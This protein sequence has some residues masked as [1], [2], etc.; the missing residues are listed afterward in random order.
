M[1]PIRQLRRLLAA[2]LAIA[3]VLA[4]SPGVLAAAEDASR[5]RSS[6]GPGLTTPD[7]LRGAE[8]P[9]TGRVLVKFERGA[10]RAARDESAGRA[11]GRVER[12]AGLGWTVVEPEPGQTPE[13]LLADLEADPL[14]DEAQLENRY[15]L[16]APPNDTHFGYQWPLNNTGTVAGDTRPTADADIDWLEAYEEIDTLPDPPGDIVVAVVDSGIDETHVDLDDVLWD[17]G[18][19]NPGWDFVGNDAD[20]LDT[21]GHGTHVAGT[22]AA[23]TDNGAGVAGVASHGTKLMILRVFGGPT[24]GGADADI[25]DAFVYA[26]DNGADIINASFTTLNPV[27]VSQVPVLR[28]AVDYAEDNGVLVVAAAGNGVGLPPVGWDNDSLTAFYPASFDNPNI[29]SVAASTWNDGLTDWSNYGVT[30]VDLAAPG[31]YKTSP[32]G[33][34]RDEILSTMRPEVFNPLYWGTFDPTNEYAYQSGTSMAAPHVAGAAALVMYKYPDDWWGSV[35]YRVLNGADTKAAFA[36]KVATGGR[37]NADRALD[38]LAPAGTMSIDAGATYTNSTNVSVDSEIFAAHS[39]GIDPTGSDPTPSITESFTVSKQVSMP[40]GDGTKTI[41]AAY[42]GLDPPI[43]YRADTIVLDTMAPSTPSG[44]QAAPGSRKA[45]L[46]WSASADE[47]SGVDGYH[48]YRA[49]S[50]NGTYTRVT[51]APV[52]GTS[53]VDEGLTNGDT[54]HYKVRSL[55]NAGNQSALSASVS[56]APEYEM[57]RAAGLDRYATAV[58][59]SQANFAAATHVV[60][61]TGEDFPDAL[62]AAGLAGAYDAPVLLTR[63]AAL[64]ADVLGEIARLG[65]TEVLVVGGTG[66]VSDA[67]ADSLASQGLSV[68]RTAGPDR[69]ATAAA[70]ASAIYAKEG[71]DWVGETFIARGDEF[72]DA[73]A[74]APFAYSQKMPVLLVRPTGSPPPATIAA[75]QNLGITRAYVA[76]GSGA[77]STAVASAL[78]VPY[79]RAA[80]PDRYETAVA[81]AR[82]G[83]ANAWGSAAF[84]G[85]ATGALFPDALGGGAAAGAND[86]VL[87]LTTPSALPNSTASFVSDH[88][89]D[90]DALQVFGGP[91]AVSEGVFSSLQ[92]LLE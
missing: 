67:V 62:A 60:L 77:V 59:V 61:A 28:D 56:V 58:A 78:G 45:Y 10:G 54:Y 8:D 40:A 57:S 79:V 32:D 17:D 76:G 34:F 66:A 23:E 55:D 49:T 38:A 14:V 3:L 88:A 30:T 85:V 20:P 35:R 81:V 15:R 80:G 31:G 7:A 84:T 50:A 29:I 90:I 9:T 82:Y 87:V 73:L 24:G 11:R 12:E 18:S 4:L 86:G 48:V 68:S 65:A 39:M 36:G 46:S 13:E 1:T 37:L 69:Y 25:L 75:I 16:A 71:P 44:L 83:E 43:L 21:D 22:V 42:E 70:V 63:T 41:Y 53:L 74:V 47:R 33:A 52:S 5:G 26:A 51:D 2:S 6:A 64:P 72:P 91:G 27:T 92:A 19:G 89:G